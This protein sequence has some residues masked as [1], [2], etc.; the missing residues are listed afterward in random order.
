MTTA[1]SEIIDAAYLKVG[2]DSATDAQDASALVNLNNMIGSWSVE[3]YSAIDVSTTNYDA[4]GSI[5]T[6]VGLPSKM[7]ETMVYNL[8]LTLG[9]D[10][11][12]VIKES[13][14]ARAKELKALFASEGLIKIVPQVDYKVK[15][16]NVV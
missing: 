5:T 3:F 4:I 8:A 12:R 11:D 14:L 1:A 13:T 6:T 2:V 7:N 9:E 15:L 16:G 10:F